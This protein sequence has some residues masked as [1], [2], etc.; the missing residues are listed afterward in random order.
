MKIPTYEQ[1]CNVPAFMDEAKVQ[2][3][4]QSGFTLTIKHW[5]AEVLRSDEDGNSLVTIKFGRNWQNG[6]RG[7]ATLVTN[8]V[9]QVAVCSLSV[10]YF[11]G[12]HS[13]ERDWPNLAYD[14][15]DSKELKGP[16]LEEYRPLVEAVF[17][18]LANLSKPQN[19]F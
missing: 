13:E 4:S 3:V 10:H 5:Q 1:L 7:L 17:I 19:W 15:V 9:K 18:T 14:L 11:E 16:P 12:P 2:E 8:K 6:P